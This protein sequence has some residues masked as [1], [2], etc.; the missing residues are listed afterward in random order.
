LTVNVEPTSGLTGA[1]IQWEY[2]DVDDPSNDGLSAAD[3]YIID[4]HDYDGGVYHKNGD[5]NTGKAYLSDGTTETTT[6]WQTFNSNYPLT[7]NHKTLIVNG[8]SYVRF[9]VKEDGG[10]NY[11]VKATL[12]NSDG[13][14][15]S[16][17]QTGIM[18]VWKRINLEYAKM[19]DNTVSLSTCLAQ[20]PS[21]FDSAFVEFAVTS[22]ASVANGNTIVDGKYV[23]GSDYSSAKN[24]CL[25]YKQKTDPGWFYILAAYNLM[26]AAPLASQ[27][28]Y[29]K[30]GTPQTDTD[31][32]TV[33]D[34]NFSNGDEITPVNIIDTG[35]PS[36]VYIFS[37][38]ATTPLWQTQ[39]K[40]RFEVFDIAVDGILLSANY[41]F[42]PIPDPARGDDDQIPLL[43]AFLNDYGFP[44]YS[45]DGST[46]DVQIWSPGT[47]G[48]YGIT[49]RLAAT[50]FM[51]TDFGGTTDMWFQRITHELVHAFY[52]LHQCGNYDCTGEK[53]CTM[54]Y[55]SHF[56]LDNSSPRQPVPWTAY[57]MGPY[58]CASH[59]MAIRQRHLEDFP[60][61]QW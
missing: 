43:S 17:D 8:H 28:L 53:A 11:I 45:T 31:T 38:D 44:D 61:F 29:P 33:W 54:N 40:T 55:E 36:D 10:N 13:I 50:V 20:L 59:I 3:G 30:N 7:D 16:C 4:E 34:F 52:L 60:R 48:T 2:I 15:I 18:T 27:L 58:L 41:Y 5:D 42:T 57:N 21:V 47:W 9:N 39:K 51:F 23:M 6:L 37:P 19:Q 14:K 1:Y 24:Y 25:N 12:Y 35:Q 26:P 22:E 56:L 46:V 49:P 32:A